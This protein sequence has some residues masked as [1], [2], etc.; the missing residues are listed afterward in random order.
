MFLTAQIIGIIAL[1]IAIISFQQNTQKRIVTLQMISSVFF[2]I[3]FFLLGAYVGAALNFI[4]IFRA[5]IFRQKG[6]KWASNILWFWLFC[7]LFMLAGILSWTNYYSIL[8]ILGMLLTTA[9][10][11]I[12]NPRLVRIVTAPSS[13]CWFIYNLVNHSYPGMLTEC[14]VFGSILVA[15][16]RFDIFPLI[17][18]KA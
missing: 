16:F 14:F 7:A 10:F 15:A 2:T 11:W 8:P 6:E 4:G 12:E 1:A 9:G 17:R 3:H 5:A 18:K 13:P